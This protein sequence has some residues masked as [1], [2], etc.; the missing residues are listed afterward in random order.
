MSLD[1]TAN[2]R[3]S[4][5]TATFLEEANRLIGHNGLF[6]Q[7]IILV[8]VWCLQESAKY[9]NLKVSI[10]GSKEGMFSSYALSILVL[11]L[12]NLVPGQLTTPLQVLR[13]FLETFSTFQFDKYVLTLDG[14]IPIQN[15]GST[16]APSKSTEQHMENRFRSL[17]ER[18]HA[19]LRCRKQ[20]KEKAAYMSDFGS[21]RLRTCNIVD[22]VDPVNNL[23]VSVTWKNFWC[24]KSTLTTGLQHLNDSLLY[25]ASSLVKVTPPT[26]SPTSVLSDSSMPPPPPTTTTSTTNNNNS[27]QLLTNTNTTNNINTSPSPPPPSTQRKPL[28]NMGGLS[29]AVTG[30]APGLIFPSTST[31]SST[32]S[33]SASVSTTIGTPNP[34]TTSPTIVPSEPSELDILS[35][36]SSSAGGNN[37][38]MSPPNNVN[39]LPNT[40]N[41]NSNNNNPP[42]MLIAPSMS[43]SPGI[44]GIA[45]GGA[46]SRVSSNGNSVIAPSPSPVPPVSTPLLPTNTIALATEYRF[47][48]RFFPNCVTCYQLEKT[49]IS[50]SQVDASNSHGNSNNNTSGGMGSGHGG[51]NSSHGS[52]N[53]SYLSK[54]ARSTSPFRDPSLGLSSHRG[55]RSHSMSC[56]SQQMTQTQ[57]RLQ[58]R[59]QSQ[60]QVQLQVNG[61]GTQPSRTISDTA[62]GSSTGGDTAA[63]GGGMGMSVGMGV[64]GQPVSFLGGATIPKRMRSQSYTSLQSTGGEPGRAK[65]TSCVGGPED[66]CDEADNMIS[67]PLQGDLAAMWEALNYNYDAHKSSNKKEVKSHTHTQF[68][69]QNKVAGPRVRDGLREGHCDETDTSD[70]LTSVDDSSP[71]I[72]PKDKEISIE[73]SPFSSLDNSSHP[74]LNTHSAD[75][76]VEEGGDGCQR[77]PEH[78]TEDGERAVPV[79]LLSPRATAGIGRPLVDQAPTVTHPTMPPLIKKMP[80][81]TVNN[82]V[83]KQ[84]N[85]TFSLF[86]SPINRKVASENNSQA[87]NSQQNNRINHA[88]SNN[89]N[90]SST[91]TNTSKSKRKKG[92][93]KDLLDSSD[94]GSK[95]KQ[96]KQAQV[97][98]PDIRAD[99]SRPNHTSNTEDVSPDR[100]TPPHEDNNNAAVQHW[101][102][103]MVGMLV[104]TTLGLAIL[105]FRGWLSPV[106]RPPPMEMRSAYMKAHQNHAYQG[107]NTGHAGG[108]HSPSSTD[109]R[110]DTGSRSK[111]KNRSPLDSDMMGSGFGKKVHSSPAIRNPLEKRGE[112]DEEGVPDA[113]GG[114]GGGDGNKEEDDERNM[115]AM[116]KF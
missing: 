47:L 97:T 55:D 111:S 60:P 82:P 50:L 44:T 10:S 1:I 106:Q 116:C 88:Q 11:Y 81:L 57:S 99:T 21:F 33:A 52:S 102:H 34:S 45:A 112:L 84:Q 76:R 18:V 77:E 27:T 90:S 75:S 65:R 9:N 85:N 16:V 70:T 42:S 49:R 113:M 103:I 104:V 4:L 79:R 23:G 69:D 48:K 95:G 28:I 37:M 5:A 71:P 25:M 89:N 105:F 7:G 39:T 41:G 24:F 12:F 100:N 36:C 114:G 66:R 68:K 87:M 62:C 64:S 73:P 3:N 83:P 109:S 94:V 96:K 74:Q 78:A 67:E 31:S 110:R 38:S 30:I 13:A 20:T 115:S 101:K 91:N 46:I 29:G 72:I 58:S 59:P 19:S 54:L 80:P 61:K 43:T 51:N 2:Q 108:T 40:N 14:P 107:T 35:P 98:D 93:S 56:S 15:G 22:P 26:P 92:K 86:E 17:A 63:G 8:K 32:T 6:K 53:G